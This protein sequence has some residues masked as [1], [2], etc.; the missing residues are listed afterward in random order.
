[1]SDRIRSL[2]RAVE[3]NP[4]DPA[5]RLLL[6]ETLIADGRV[7]DGLAEYEV[8]L[9]LD[10]LPG[11]EALTAG[12]LAVS[13]GRLDLARGLVE[14]ARRHGVV[15]GVAALEHAISEALEARGLQR[16]P[17]GPDPD[18]PLFLVDPADAR[19]FDDVGGL[20]EVKRTIH[21]AIIL[22]QTR[23]ELY[24]RYRRR[25]GGGV[26]LYGP[27]GCGKTLLARATAGECHLPFLNVRIEQILDPWLGVSEQ[28]LHAAFEA[29]RAAAP[30]VVFLDELDGLA[31]ARRKQAGSAARTLVDLLLQELD[32]MGAD[33]RDV[34]VLAA[35]NTPWD[36]DDALL[37]PGRFDR[38]IFVP[39]PDAP[40]RRTILEL[41][42]DGVP[43]R[44]VDVSRVASATALF[45]GADLR[46]MVELAIDAVI[47]E[48]LVRGGEPPLTGAHL[49]EAVASVRPT[50]IEWLARARNYVEFANADDRYDDVAEYLRR[51]EVRRSIS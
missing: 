13:Q 3:A 38:R 51:R 47:E 35:S 43:T 36:I 21:R 42:L 9:S 16:V 34:L 23:P 1:M 25:V 27:P 49:V 46:A 18:A 48:A 15:D 10:A 30:C 22:P 11:T 31:Y 37:R 8:L 2:R 24:E 14:A 26:L 6:A 39:P 4:S 28:N 17:A 41:L 40:A 5:L 29:A 20:D 44:D 7:S 33:N 45:S 32:A 50:T 19:T 12:Q